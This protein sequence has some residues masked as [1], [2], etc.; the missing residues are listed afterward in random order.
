MDDVK[1]P[2]SPPDSTNDSRGKPRGP[3]GSDPTTADEKPK[4]SASLV[5]STQS[6]QHESVTPAVDGLVDDCDIPETIVEGPE[7]EDDDEVGNVRDGDAH[8]PVLLLP[9][10]VGGDAHERPEQGVLPNS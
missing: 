8:K 6:S 4:S 5:H 2:P 10:L 9:L 3:E 1:R 7:E